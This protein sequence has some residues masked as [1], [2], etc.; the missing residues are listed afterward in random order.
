MKFK[1]KC[2][3]CTYND[4]SSPNTLIFFIFQYMYFLYSTKLVF[5]N[6]DKVMLNQACSATETS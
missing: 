2:V 3:L 6:S 5:S 4:F 1:L